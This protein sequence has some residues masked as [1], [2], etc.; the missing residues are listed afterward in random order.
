M[1]K[2]V[3]WVLMEIFQKDLI[4]LLKLLKDFTQI[5]EKE[6]DFILFGLRGT[7]GW[8]GKKI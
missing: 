8:E 7:K 5:S 3:F 4:H 6:N 1:V 2:R